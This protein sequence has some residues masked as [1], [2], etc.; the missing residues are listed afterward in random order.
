MTG[1]VVGVGS[2]SGALAPEWA[3]HEAEPWALPLV[4][5]SARGCFGP[6]RRHFAEK[7]LAY[8]PKP[9]EETP[10][11][12]MGGAPTTEPTARSQ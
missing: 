1:V 2:E 12:A 4:V 9:N 8:H 6:E 11:A 5:V 7:R 3:V 10:G